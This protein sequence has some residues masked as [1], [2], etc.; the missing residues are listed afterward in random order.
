MD[1]QRRWR[2]LL[3]VPVLV[4]LLSIGYVVFD[5]RHF[6]SLAK[7]GMVMPAGMNPCPVS[8]RRPVTDFDVISMVQSSGPGDQASITFIRDGYAV[9]FES[10]TG[11]VTAVVVRF[12]I[13]F[14]AG[15]FINSIEDAAPDG[16]DRRSIPHGVS[17]VQR[18]NRTTMTCVAVVRKGDIAVYASGTGDPDIAQQA[19]EAIY[20][21]L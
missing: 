16:F 10:P 12:G 15:G 18:S 4:V 17:F 1:S 14:F 21:W 2:L 20:A 5:G 13:S 7:Y 19:A 9:C 6:G 11:T 8:P 3:G